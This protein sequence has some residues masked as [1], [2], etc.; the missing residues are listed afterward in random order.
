MSWR[1]KEYTSVN[2]LKVRGENK[3]KMAIRRRLLGVKSHSRVEKN[4]RCLTL[5]EGLSRR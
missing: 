2:V 1:V 3:K 5:A 4:L